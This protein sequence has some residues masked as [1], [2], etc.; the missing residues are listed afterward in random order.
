MSRE[1]HSP[2]LDVPAAQGKFSVLGMSGLLC[3]LPN[4][5]VHTF[6]LNALCVPRIG[7]LGET[8]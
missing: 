2:Y 4:S 1:C 6:S 7:E 3:P 8:V 5:I